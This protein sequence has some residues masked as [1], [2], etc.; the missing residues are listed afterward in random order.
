LTG[1]NGETRKCGTGATVAAVTPDLDPLARPSPVQQRLE[2]RDNQSWIA[3]N[4]EVGPV[5][6][7][8]RPGRL[9]PL[10]EVKPEVR[11]RIATI[12]I[13]PSERN[14][15]HLRVVGQHDTSA[16]EMRFESVVLVIRV[17]ARC[18]LSR[19]VPERSTLAAG[20]HDPSLDHAA[21]IG[22][23]VVGVATEGP[24]ENV[25]QNASIQARAALKSLRLSAYRDCS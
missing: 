19:G 8:V 15:S 20:D 23:R 7:V 9:P 6:R 16:V 18:K 12:R 1:K 2:R 5:Q 13:D 4:P 10:V 24:A 21:T 17:L 3:G 11:R 25:R 14:G 22:P